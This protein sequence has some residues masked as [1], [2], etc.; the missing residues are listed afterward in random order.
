LTNWNQDGIIHQSTAGKGT[1]LGFG[2]TV[3]PTQYVNLD[4]LLRREDFETASEPSSQPR[5]TGDL[6]LSE[7]ESTG[8]L[9]QILRKPDFQRETANWTPEKVADLIKCFLDGDLIPSI[10][11]WRSPTSG[12]IFVIDGAHRLSALMA[13]VYDDYGDKEI[14]LRFFENMIP[15]EQEK[16]AQKTRQLIKESVGTYQQLKYVVQ[17]PTSASS[18]S[19]LMR[20]R[21]MGTFKIDLQWVTGNS[22]NAEASFFK[23]NQSATPIDDTEFEMIKARHK[24]N[25]LAARAL[26]RA[27]TGH[28]YW[29]AFSENVRLEIE[30]IAREVYE[31][32]FKPVLETPIKTLDVP[33]A[34]KGY[35]ADSVRM[36]FELVNFVNKPR[37]QNVEQIEQVR[38]KR[39]SVKVVLPDDTDGS[40]TLA[41][42]KS[43]KKAAARIAGQSPSSLGLHPVV[44]FY[45]ATGKFLPTAF[46]AAVAFAEELDVANK[47]ADFTGARYRFEE[48]LVAHREFMNLFPRQ[49]GSRTRGLNPLLTMY[50]IM[51]SQIQKGKNNQEVLD[52]IFAEPKLRFLDQVGKDDTKRKRFSTETKT[53]AFLTQALE[54]S[55]RC[56]ICKARMHFKSM[57]VD[58][59]AGIKDGGL[60]EVDNAQVT[61]PYCNSAKDKLIAEGKVLSSEGSDG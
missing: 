59:K 20:A 6:R 7:L 33:V 9:S 2:G 35:S 12:N 53:A 38:R 56:P 18:E 17:N 48:F 22:A 39:T 30:K 1:E 24:P 42:L 47:L 54:N 27:G 57:S 15:P 26:I 16:I 31:T 36:M 21:N 60:G 44:Y 4:A 41:F 10:I 23:I 25:A 49:F 5:L 32:L 52:A 8:V 43:V 37:V 11:M 55:V 46:L 29:S 28:K 40:H 3:V 14:S 61:H 34:G 51:L 45:G 13:W 19:L 58:H 50:R